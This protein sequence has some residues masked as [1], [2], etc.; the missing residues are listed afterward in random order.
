MTDF[1]A[2]IVGAGAGGGVAAWVL[3]SRGW[4]VALIEKG[5]NPYPTLSA[6]TLEGSLLGNDEVRRRRYFAFQDPFIEPRVYRAGASATP[7]VREIQG[8]GVTVGGGTVQ[9]DG[10]SPRLQKIDFQRLSMLGPVEGATVVDWPIGYDD[11]APYYD[12]VE[13]LIGVQG[14]AGPGGDP[15][16]EARGP[17][18]MPPGHPARAGVLLSEAA[19]AMGY[20]PHPMPM[21][22]NSMG[23][24][25]RP[26]CVNCGFCQFGCPVNA[27]GS[28]AVTVVRDALRT[29]NLTLLSECCVTALDMEPSGAHARG[30]RYLDPKG[31]PQL[32]T[33]RHV[34]VAA[35]AIETP[36]LLLAS[37]TSAQPDGVGNASGL[38]GR[39]LMFHIVF[40]AIGV[41]DQELRSYRGRPI[42]HAMADFTQPD[43]SVPGLRGGYV[44]LGGQLHPLEE[45]VSYPW[46]L[47]KELMINGRYRRK[48][49][50]VS[51]I[52]EDVPSLDNRVELDPKVR[53]V[54][55]RPAPRI[56]YG[57]HPK[58]Q[59]MVDHYAPK[60]SAIAKAAGAKEII[61]VDFVKQ[62]GRPES[63]HLLG[64]ARMGTDPKR[65]V[66]DP[67]G[68]LHDVDNVWIADGSTWP[69]SAA[70]NPTLTQQA[71]AHRTAAYVVDPKAPKP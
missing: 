4:K 22:I 2:V 62:D 19:T 12:E 54:Y 24:R 5:R 64:T 44:E 43:A 67:W 61:D 35:N 65:S 23:Y 10:D 7:Q 59:A 25:G 6:D 51:M 27:K 69:T 9:Y 20:H 68:R 13:R 46:L 36:R 1:D 18:P 28:T 55:G 15:F 50:S 11:L 53:D 52:G 41:F 17:Y 16:A 45:G 14:L 8:L 58:D 31:D 29:G 71:L 30:V 63:K 49:A 33:A 26:A 40:A 38:L 37:A 48:I 70:F 34:I 42:T 47:H 39:N 56:T 60:L 66:T 3:A 57:R 21:A 32:V